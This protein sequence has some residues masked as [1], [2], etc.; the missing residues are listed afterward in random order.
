MRPARPPRDDATTPPAPPCPP[1]P[2]TRAHRHTTHQHANHPPNAG[3]NAT[4]PPRSTSPCPAPNTP[5]NPAIPSKARRPDQRQTT[6]MSAAN[7]LQPLPTT[8]HS[9]THPPPTPPQHHKTR[10]PASPPRRAGRAR[11]A[12]RSNRAPTATGSSPRRSSPCSSGSPPSSPPNAFDPPHPTRRQQLSEPRA[13]RP[14]IHQA[15]RF[16][17]SVHGLS[18]NEPNSAGTDRHAPNVSGAKA[19]RTPHPPNGFPGAL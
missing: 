6:Q 11:R 12:H 1:T 9:P 3:A 18:T 17:T 15:A 7:R 14:D 8:T 4:K 16:A 10:Q 2:T 13:A 5:A 19:L